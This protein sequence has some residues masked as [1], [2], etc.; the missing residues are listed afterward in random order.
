[1]ARNLIDRNEIRA[2]ADRAAGTDK[3]GGNPRVKEIMRR[4]LGDLFQAIDDLDISMNE[5]WSAVA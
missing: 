1:M 4:L 3:E 2:L 5:V